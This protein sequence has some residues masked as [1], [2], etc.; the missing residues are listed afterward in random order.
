M[1]F[2]EIA[3]ELWIAFELV[4]S[5][6][7][8]QH[9][10]NDWRFVHCCELLSNLYLRHIENNLHNNALGIG[11]LWIAFELVSSSY[12]K[13]LRKYMVPIGC[14]C[15]LLS[16]LYLR[17]IENNCARHPLADQQVVNC[18]RTCIF[19]ILKTTK[20]SEVE[21]PKSCELLSNLYLRHIENNEEEREKLWLEL[22]IAF[23]LV[24][25]SYW[26]Q[27][28]WSALGCTVGCELLSN[29][30]LRHIENNLLKYS[31][32]ATNVVNCFRTCIFVILKTTPGRIPVALPRLWI[33]FE[34]VSS[35]Y[36]KQQRQRPRSER[37]RCELLSNL[38][39][40][41]IEN[42]PYGTYYGV[43][44]LWIAFELVSSSYW[45]QPK[46]KLGGICVSCELLSNLYLRHIENNI[47]AGERTA[48]LVV[49]CFRT[50][51]FVILKTT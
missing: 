31:V 2:N 38:Y 26:K 51:I 42:N 50:C 8:K 45:K 10:H 4:S 12:W 33:A 20:M 49:N 34:L 35:S 37:A 18:F 14:G 19:V 5:S 43:H 23:E 44:M 40:R 46:Y 15:E 41:H 1:T 39:L 17:H 22:W 6:Y 9:A 28:S 30:Y 16:N 27:Q 21:L 32:Y 29:L 47:E 3:L 11:L 7:W 48:E 24:S 36:W 25:S 13:Q